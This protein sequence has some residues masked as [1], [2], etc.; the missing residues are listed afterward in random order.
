QAQGLD[1]SLE[2][3]LTFLDR[4]ACLS[5]GI[6]DVARRDRAVELPAFARLPNDHDSQPFEL[7]ANFRRFALSLQVIRLEL[8]ALALEIRQVFL[9]CP[10]R[11]FLR[12]QIIARKPGLYFDKLAHLAQLFD[13][14]EQDQ[15]NHR[16]SSKCLW[17][18]KT[19][20]EP[21][22]PIDQSQ[23]SDQ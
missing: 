14:L 11:F 20:P 2:N 5:N 16:I 1:R 23:N 19:P 9:C 21:E 12:Q 22:R 15:F 7:A 18:G 13:T 8:R 3:H 6:G 4:E 17:M 10:Q